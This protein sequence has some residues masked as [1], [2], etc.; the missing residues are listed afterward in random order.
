M[1]GREEKDIT[2]VEMRA[3]VCSEWRR[4]VCLG[5]VGWSDLDGEER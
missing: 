2:A 5:W 3:L 4:R 1:T